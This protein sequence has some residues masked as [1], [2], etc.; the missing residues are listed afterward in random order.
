MVVFPAFFSTKRRKLCFV[1]NVLNNKT[2]ILLNHAEYRLILANSAIS[3][4]NGHTGFDVIVFSPFY[5]TLR[6]LTWDPPFVFPKRLSWENS[7]SVFIPVKNNKRQI[8]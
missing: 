2:I 6:S 1:T 8:Q 4:D 5:V 3:Q 7:S